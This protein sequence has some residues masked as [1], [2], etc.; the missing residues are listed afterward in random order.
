MNHHY[1]DI[2]N[3]IPEPPSWWDEYAVPRYCAFAPDELANIYADEAALFE[4]ECQGCRRAFMVAFSSSASERV[5]RHYPT[6]AE[7]I[8]EGLLHY[9][10]PPNVGCCAAGP[11]MNCID[12]RVVEYWKQPRPGFDWERDA[13]LEMALEKNHSSCAADTKPSSETA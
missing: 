11:T 9:G 2:R 13:S 6:I 7:L 4:V 10:D 8:R 5:L 12:V 1:L 3:R